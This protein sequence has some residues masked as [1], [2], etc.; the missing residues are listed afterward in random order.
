MKIIKPNKDGVKYMRSYRDFIASSNKNGKFILVPKQLVIDPTLTPTEKLLWIIMSAFLFK[1]TSK[2]FPSR[3]R[4]AILISINR[5]N[6]ISKITKSLQKKA[7]MEKSYNKY[8]RVYYE[9]YFCND[10]DDGLFKDNIADMKI[11]Q[12]AFRIDSN[13]MMKKVKN[14]MMTLSP[15]LPTSIYIPISAILRYGCHP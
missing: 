13:M 9:P 4:L 3:E 6:S 12:Q 14:Q 15:T 1:S 8:R 10:A 5:A 11:S 2:I 7:Y